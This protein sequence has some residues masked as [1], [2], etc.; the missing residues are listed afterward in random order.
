MTRIDKKLTL[1]IGEKVIVSSVVVYAMPLMP[2]THDSKDG[3][4][5]IDDKDGPGVRST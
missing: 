4:E 1:K 5:Q 3:N 2:Q